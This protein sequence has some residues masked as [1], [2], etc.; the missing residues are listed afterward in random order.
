MKVKAQG[1]GDLVIGIPTISNCY[2]MVSSSL[3]YSGADTVHYQFLDHPSGRVVQ[4]NTAINNPADIAGWGIVYI[5]DYSP[6]GSGLVVFEGQFPVSYIDE[7]P[8]NVTRIIATPLST[9]TQVA[10]SVIS[11]S[12][13]SADSAF[14]IVPVDDDCFTFDL[15]KFE[16]STQLSGLCKDPYFVLRLATDSLWEQNPINPGGFPRNISYPFQGGPNFGTTLNPDT[17]CDPPH[18]LPLP[19]G[20]EPP[21]PRCTEFVLEIQLVP[22]D[23]FYTDPRC[24]I[25]N[26]PY[27]VNICCFCNYVLES[28]GN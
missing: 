2:Q 5:D 19:P 4:Y 8:P 12:F 25:L 28:A 24:P 21:A 18:E 23:D 20:P 6:L 7:V 14:N 27:P 11:I 1:S 17:L 9:Q 10:L 16:Y 26:I 3:L 13:I 15:F 22:C